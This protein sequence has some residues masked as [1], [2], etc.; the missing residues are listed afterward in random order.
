MSNS[1]KYFKETVK[2][3]FSGLT[4]IVN[5]TLESTKRYTVEFINDENG[6][7]TIDVYNNEKRKILSV[8]YQLL[9]TYDVKAGLFMWACDKMLVDKKMTEMS[10][11]VKSYSKDLKK[12]IISNKYKDVS[13]LE[14]LYY[15]TTNNIFFMNMKYLPDLVMFSIFV[16]DGQGILSVVDNVDGIDIQSFYIVTDVISF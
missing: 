8:N 7:K 4:K 6:N 16:T 5:E 3:K 13:F 14:R 11:D 15:F 9:G 12:M 1:K 2:M 10:K